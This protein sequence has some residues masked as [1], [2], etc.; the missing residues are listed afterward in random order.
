MARMNWVL[1][2]FALPSLFMGITSGSQIHFFPL[3]SIRFSLKLFW[4]MYIQSTGEMEGK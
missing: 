1:A 3:R 4:G 2:L